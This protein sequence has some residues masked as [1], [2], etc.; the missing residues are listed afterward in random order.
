MDMIGYVTL[1]TSDL[2][3][4][5]VF[6]DVVLAPLGAQ[7]VIDTERMVHWGKPGRSGMLALIKP[8]DRQPASVGNGVMVALSARSRELVEQV[9]GLAL[10]NGASDEGAPGVRLP[11]F[12]GA[13]FRDLDGHKLCVY[14]M[15]RE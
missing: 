9:H 10:A 1:G 8:Y 12:Y 15:L 7:R 4:A 11:Q 3:R 14:T 2:A 6:Y 5:G 13:Y